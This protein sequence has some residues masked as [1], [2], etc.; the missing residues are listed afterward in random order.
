[1]SALYDKGRQK[2]LEGSIAWLTDT[3]KVQF[4]HSASYPAMDLASDEFL[5]DVPS[6]ARVGSPQTLGSKTSTAGVADGEDCTFPA[7]TGSSVDAVLIYKEGAGEGS[8]P[9]IAWIDSGTGLP[10]TPNGGDVVIV[11]SSGVSKIFK[12]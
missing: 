7:F 10:F 1:M 5:S 4:I 6:G 8:S 11:W 9:L 3:I 12:L 2:F